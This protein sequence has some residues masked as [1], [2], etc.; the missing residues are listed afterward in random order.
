MKIIYFIFFTIKLRFWQFEVVILQFDL[1]FNFVSL[2][3]HIFS[4]FLHFSSSYSLWQCIKKEKEK[5]KNNTGT[6]LTL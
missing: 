4:P 6:D 3:Y 1:H 2:Y 5:R